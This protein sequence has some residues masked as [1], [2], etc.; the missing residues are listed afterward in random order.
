[1]GGLVYAPLGPTHLAIDDIA[2]LR[3][4]P[5]MTIVAPCDAEEMKRLMPLTVDHDGP[6]YIRLAKGGDPVVSTG[7]I[8]FAIGKALPIREGK[9]VLIVTTG[10]TLRMAL[11]AADVLKL[12]GI[13]AAILHMPTIKPLD[14]QTLLHYVSQVPGVV[15]VEEHTIIGGLGS[16]VLEAVAEA[17]F[18]AAKRFKRIGIPDVFADHYGSQDDLMSYYG[19]DIQHICSAAKQL[20]SFRVKTSV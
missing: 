19:I 4:V 3:A 15:T 12:E 18:G 14:I 11:Q 17:D 1:G 8:P 10:I 20:H 5:N 7:S 16:A 2:I 13:E 9:D 6:M